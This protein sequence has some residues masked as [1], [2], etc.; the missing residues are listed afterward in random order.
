M[1]VCRYSQLKL[2]F[3]LLTKVD[4][5]DLD[6]KLQP[7]LD[8][9][10]REDDVLGKIAQQYPLCKRSL[11]ALEQAKSTKGHTEYKGLA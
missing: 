8:W 3:K 7:L 11:D 1:P 5:V 6:M 10:L 4:P 2:E 9:Y